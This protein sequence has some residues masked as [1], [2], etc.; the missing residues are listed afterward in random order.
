MAF[1]NYGKMLADFLLIGSLTPEDLPN[2]LGIDGQEHAEKVVRAGRG[3]II[4]LPHM[5]S[6]DFAG[7]LGLILGYRL[8]AVA[9]TFPGSLDEAVLE[10]RSLLGMDVIPLGRSAVRA[11]N[12][13]LDRGDMVALMCDLPPPGAGGVEVDFFGKRAV[14]PSGPAAIAIKR[15]VPLLPAYCRRD[16]PGHYHVHVDPPL[17]PPA[18][19]VGGHREASAAMMQQVMRRFERFIG[20]HPDQ[21]YAFKQVVT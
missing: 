18:A 19:T 2:H 17:P 4:A 14:V 5:G 15:Q 8:S 20:D 7:G 9:E 12:R 3:G 1:Q 16:G 10:A 13:V 6:W 21:W 11:V